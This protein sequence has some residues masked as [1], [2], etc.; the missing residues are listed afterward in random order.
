MSSKNILTFRVDILPVS[1]K[2]MFGLMEHS[3]KDILLT[4]DQSITDALSCCSSKNIFYQIAPWKITFGHELAKHLPNKFLKSIKTSCGT[5]KAIRYNSNYKN[6]IK[7]WDFR[8][9]AKPKMD[10]IMKF[11]N[12]QKDN[13]KDIEELQSI[14]VNSRTM[15]TILAKL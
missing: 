13:R 5:L 10:A 12:Y 6:F 15:K 14:I 4:G 9:L 8:I 3:V 2:D 7:N 1:N 11:A